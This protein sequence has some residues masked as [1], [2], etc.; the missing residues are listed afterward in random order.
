[1]T[2]SP[3]PSDKVHPAARMHASEYFAGQIGRREF[4]TR[5]TALGVGGAAAYSL[6]NAAQPATA[7]PAIK[8]GG[9]LRI[10]MT[11]K[12]LG[13]PRTYEWSEPGNQTRGFL[14]YLVE[15]E[16]DG[17]FRP[18]LLQGWEVNEDATGYILHLRKGIKWNNGDDFTARDVER[19]IKGW[20]DTDLAANSMASRMGGL[21]DDESGQLRD[22]AV[23]TPDDHTVV[24]TLSTPD[25]ALIANMSDFPAAITHASYTGGD[26]FENGI[27][28]G[29]F[30]P[31]SIEVGKSCILERATDHPWWGTE[32]Y[33]GPYVDRVEF[34]D[35]GPDPFNWVSA[36]RAGEIDLLYETVGDVI[37]VMD[38]IGWTKTQTLTAATIVLR[39]NQNAEVDGIK[40]YADTRVRRA[41]ALAVNNAVLLELGYTNRGE[42]A[43]NHHVC[44][45]HPAYVDIGAAP[46]DP[47]QA[48]ELLQAAGMA[49]YEHNLITID[50]DWQRN[51]GDAM[52][53]QLLD[54]GIKVRRTIL[55]GP[56]FRQDWTSHPFSAT[57]WNHRPLEIQILTLAYRSGTA[58]NE[59]GYSSPEFDRLITL[60]NSI[61]VADKR[62]EV[63]RQIEQ[64]LREDAVIVQPYWRSLYNHH[65]G[66]LINAERHPANEI[67]L[68][69]IGF[70]G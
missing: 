31:V 20:C 68:Y 51:T 44:P 6:I 36:A 70:A 18:M 58:W 23:T 43:A 55:P 8:S 42:I 40:P 10:E 25:V 61:A 57:Q 63:I 37:D 64:L 32:I 48:R 34:I 22:G 46:F 5:A 2:Q 1:M 12:A 29:P 38:M 27:G 7:Q 39:G 4:L 50:D 54:A 41:L 19:N 14:E 65:I 47:E 13:D 60:A 24:L 59:T 56:R 17:S 66:S 33:G 62:R 53:A 45:I 26:P 69:K 52:A 35:Y 16:S 28:T 49:D 11:V 9:T 15:Y 21:I 67:H 30:R 3:P